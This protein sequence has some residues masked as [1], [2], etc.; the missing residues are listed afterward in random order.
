MYHGMQDEDLNSR[1]AL[2]CDKNTLTSWTTAGSQKSCCFATLRKTV[3]SMAT[4]MVISM[5]SCQIYTSESFKKK[6]GVPA[7]QSSIPVQIY[8][9]PNILL[10]SYQLLRTRWV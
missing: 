8:P 2:L 3:I 6:T 5:E 9:A 1:V 10:Q 4:G 7:D